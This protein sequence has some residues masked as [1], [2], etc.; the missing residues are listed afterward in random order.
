MNKV[1]IGDII[2]K[3]LNEL[4]MKKSEFARLMGKERQN[5]NSWLNK[6]D[7]Y[8]QELQKASKE[9]K[10][11]LFMYLIDGGKYAPEP[12]EIFEEEPGHYLPKRDLLKEKN[13]V[14]DQLRKCI[15][16]REYMEKE[17][18]LLHRTNELLEEKLR[19]AS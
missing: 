11:D 5:I 16:E 6:G 19:Q 1:P 4:G 10:L 18:K 8:V 15:Q 3:R 17:N 7:F 12:G 2:Q 13:Q 9:L 14:E